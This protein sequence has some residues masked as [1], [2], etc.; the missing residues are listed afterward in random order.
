TSTSTTAPSPA[1]RCSCSTTTSASGSTRSSRTGK[2]AERE[3]GGVRETGGRGIVG[4][5]RD[6]HQLAAE[7]PERGQD[8]DMRRRSLSGTWGGGA[9]G[10]RGRLP[11]VAIAAGLV[12]AGA[13][14]SAA[15]AQ[16]VAGPMPRA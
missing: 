16:E 5:D 7:P 1:A 10:G 4:G 14:S 13:L 12:V 2:G 9:R 11:C 3:R 8:G 15:S 6:H